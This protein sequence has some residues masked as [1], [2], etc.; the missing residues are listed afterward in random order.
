MATDAIS[1]VEVGYTLQLDKEDRADCSEEWRSQRP[2][3][4]VEE[5]KKLKAS[6]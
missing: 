3:S 4:E 6:D 2:P 1:T 5:C